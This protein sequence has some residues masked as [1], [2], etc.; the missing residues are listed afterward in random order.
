VDVDGDL[1][2]DVS[3]EDITAATTGGASMLP[4]SRSR[5]QRN[6]ARRRVDAGDEARRRRRE[7]GALRRREPALLEPPRR[8]GVARGESQCLSE[9]WAWVE[10]NYRPHAYQKPQTLS[11]S[12]LEKANAPSSKTIH[13]PRNSRTLRKSSSSLQQ[14]TA[15]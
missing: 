3:D 10:L 8:S 2:R 12:L 5:P 1:P 11:W 15:F 7:Q 13:I 14:T 9:E 4:R 6:L